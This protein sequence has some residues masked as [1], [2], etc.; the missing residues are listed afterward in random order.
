MNV[1]IMVKNNVRYND[2]YLSK[3]KRWFWIHIKKIKKKNTKKE[4][5]FV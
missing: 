1:I 2:S 4:E 5:R 3:I